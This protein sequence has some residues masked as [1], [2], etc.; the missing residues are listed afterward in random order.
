MLTKYKKHPKKF[1]ITLAFES[2]FVD[3]FNSYDSFFGFAFRKG[4]EQL[5]RVKINGIYYINEN[6]IIRYL[7]KQ[8][9]KELRKN[10]YLELVYEINDAGKLN[11][12][13]VILGYKNPNQVYDIYNY[14]A[15]GKKTL[16]LLRK[17]YKKLVELLAQD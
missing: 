14:G 16:R 15:M 7:R 3:R 11:R 6:D 17:N 13:G 12:A 5:K 9:V 4:K 8:E 10:K 1:T 2:Y